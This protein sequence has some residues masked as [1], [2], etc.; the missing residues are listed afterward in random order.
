MPRFPK[1]RYH[2]S[3][4]RVAFGTGVS[5]DAPLMGI[6][7]DSIAA[8]DLVSTLSQRLGTELEPTTL[9]DQVGT[10]WAGPGRLS[11][12]LSYERVRLLEDASFTMPA[13]STSQSET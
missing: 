9:F 12:N 6:G 4:I 11:A 7:L 8:V 10:R 3:S 13:L 5:V 2:S 1:I